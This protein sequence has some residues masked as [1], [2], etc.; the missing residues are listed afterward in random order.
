MTKKQSPMTLA[1]L[2][3]GEPKR[4]LQ[5]HLETGSKRKFRGLAMR[6]NEDNISEDLIRESDSKNIHFP[7][8]KDPLVI[9]IGRMHDGE[10]EKPIKVIRGRAKV[11]EMLSGRYQLYLETQPQTARRIRR[12]CL[13]VDGDVTPSGLPIPQYA[14][15]TNSKYASISRVSCL[16]VAKR[17]PVMMSYDLI[18]IGRNLVTEYEDADGRFFAFGDRMSV[19]FMPYYES[20]IVGFSWI[21]PVFPVTYPAFL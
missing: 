6:L 10:G 16:I 12:L 21:F 17:H 11:Q 4:G 15:T 8:G 14:V 20:Q 5:R 1:R 3:V 19:E 2:R 7:M 9:V 18:K 13:A